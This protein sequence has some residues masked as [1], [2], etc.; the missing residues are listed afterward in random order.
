M[1]RSTQEKAPSV[2][3][4]YHFLFYDIR[5]RLV[6]QRNGGRGGECSTQGKTAAEN[7]VYELSL[8]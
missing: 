7:L 3:D 5:C 8:A 1:T 2:V 6:W 4:E